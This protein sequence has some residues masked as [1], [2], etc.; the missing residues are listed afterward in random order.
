MQLVGRD[1]L[2]CSGVEKH[3]LNAPIIAIH[4][5]ERLDLCGFEGLLGG[6]MECGIVAGLVGQVIL[7]RESDTHGIRLA[8][9]GEQGDLGM[10]EK[11]FVIHRL[12]YRCEA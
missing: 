4:G 8:A 2:S 12:Q 11:R 9:V 1:L 7:R 3:G 5:M 10:G 6:V